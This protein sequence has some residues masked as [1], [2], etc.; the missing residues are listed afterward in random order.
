[1]TKLFKISLIYTLIAAFGQV[2]S[3]QNYQLQA[4]Y[5]E[6]DGKKLLLPSLGG[7]NSPQFANLDL[8]LDGKLDIIVLEKNSGK[9]VPIL[10][11]ENKHEIDYSI[12]NNL[13]VISDWLICKDYNGDGKID[14]FTSAA[15]GIQL[16]KNI[17]TS[18]LQ[19]EL[20]TD[21]V[22]SLRVYENQSFTANIFVT[23]SD[24]PLIDDLDGDGDL[25]ILTFALGGNTIEYHKNLSVEKSGSADIDFQLVNSCYAYVTDDFSGSAFELGVSECLDNVVNPEKR[26]KHSGFTFNLKKGNPKSLLVGELNSSKI[27]ELIIGESQFGGDSA[28]AQNKSFPI[29]APN[30]LLFVAAYSGLFDLDN[31]EDLILASNIRGSATENSVWLYDDDHILKK[32]NFLQDQTIEV[33]EHANVATL[34]WDSD[35]DKDIMISSAIRND[36]LLPQI[37]FWENIGSPS[38]PQYRFIKSHLGAFE[39]SPPLNIS[40]H[41]FGN[42]NTVLIGNS[43]GLIWEVDFAD[44][45]DHG[46]SSNRNILTDPNNDPIQGSANSTP[47]KI[48]Y[49]GQETLLIGNGTGRIKH[50]SKNGNSYT[51]VTDFFKSIDLR[52]SNIKQEITLATLGDSL[53]VFTQNGAVFTYSLLDEAPIGKLKKNYKNMSGTRSTG[54]LAD[55]NGDESPELI[56]GTDDGGILIFSTGIISDIQDVSE[57]LFSIYP[58]PATNEIRIQNVTTKLN[59]AVYNL[60]GQTLMTGSTASSINI[61]SL[62]SGQYF[63]VL[64]NNAHLETHRFWK[65]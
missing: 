59:Y 1:V 40:S 57:K 23:F 27:V 31:S 21:L 53:W 2:V 22:S 3:A 15:G 12:I 41:S 58:N 16:Y 26:A 65:Q 24:I 56:I 17:S 63:L 64:Q 30:N 36:F 49:Q 11:R 25:D 48:M 46:F 19:F 28:I 52:G 35:G 38:L 10:R 51:L 32:N 18:S 13:P 4:P 42:E 5:F 7:L 9:V 54:T 33:G 47:V 43:E 45:F 8:N 37:S 55:L 50:F 61:K 14:I 44:L 62:N 39:L 60:V 6:K 20:V 34:D 29:E